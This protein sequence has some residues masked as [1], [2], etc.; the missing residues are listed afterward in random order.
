MRSLSKGEIFL[1]YNNNPVFNAI[2][3]RMNEEFSIKKID[4]VNPE[5]D[6]LFGDK[7]RFKLLP[8]DFKCEV[9]KCVRNFIFISQNIEIPC[10]IARPFLLEAP[11]YDNKLFHLFLFEEC[12]LSDG[13][14]YFLNETKVRM[15]NNSS[16]GNL[17][18]SPSLLKVLKTQKNM[19]ENPAKSHSLSSLSADLDISPPYLSNIFKNHSGISLSAF[20]TKIKLCNALWELVSTEKQIKTIAL[21]LGYKP[22]YF[23]NKFRAS[24]GVPPSDIRNNILYSNL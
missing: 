3:S 9:Q 18:Y 2:E 6:V 23:S 5:L 21:D 7:I 17:Y 14:K 12:Q 4:P 8:C 22:L 20:S 16:S 13:Q 15:N 10:L 24:F 11:I 19:S 1:I